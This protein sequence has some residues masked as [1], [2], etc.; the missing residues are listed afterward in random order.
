MWEKSRGIFTTNCFSEPEVFHFP[1]G[2]GPIE[3]VNVEHEE[4]LLMPREIECNRVTFKYGL[5]TDFINW[6]KTFAYLGLDSAEKIQVGDVKV[7]PRDVLAAVLPNPAKLGHLMTGK[8]CAGTWVKGLKDGNPRE[9]YLYH[10][11]DNQ[12]TMGDWGCQ[13]VLWQTAIC[14]VV[15]LE[16]IASGTWKHS[17]VRGPEAFDA[18][19][20]LELLAEYGAPHGMVEMGEGQWP[21]PTRTDDSGWSRPVRKPTTA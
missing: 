19:P 9:V 20:Y 5:G 13:A 15:A 11:V 14:P 3:C 18:V 1:E 10:V 17:G 6:L 12:E 16:L 21:S 8:T 7:A 2:I 4:V